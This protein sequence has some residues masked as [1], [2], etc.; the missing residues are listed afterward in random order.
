MKTSKL[1]NLSIIFVIALFALTLASCGAKQIDVTI[2]D[3][4]TTSKVTVEDGKTV[5]DALQ[6]AHIEVGS[7]DDVTPALDSKINDK[8]TEI[9]ITRCISAQVVDGER[10]IDVN[11]LGGG[12]VADALAQAEI[13]LEDGDTV[14]PELQDPVEEGMTI[15][16]TYAPV[17]EPTPS[18]DYNYSNSYVATEQ[19]AGRTVVSKTPV[20]SC[21]DPNHGYYEILYS[22]GTMEYVEY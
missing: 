2:I 22:D 21:G 17:V 8:T 14:D 1:I 13:T 6:A 10:V 7:N 3:G 12:T 18:Y 9:V 4:E 11:L 16:I 19:P 5:E 20:P 15:T